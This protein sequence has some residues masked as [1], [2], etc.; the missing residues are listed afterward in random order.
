M[1]NST[2]KAVCI[3][4]SS[5]HVDSASLTTPQ[6]TNARSAAQNN[7]YLHAMESGDFILQLLVDVL[8]AAYEADG[9]Q[10][11]SMACKR[12]CGSR[13]QCRVVG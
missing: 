3:D 8:G 5:H 6:N 1:L 10:T 7:T 13:H 2:N 11:I 4:T 9:R 12:L